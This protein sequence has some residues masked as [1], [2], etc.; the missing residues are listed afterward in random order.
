VRLRHI[1]ILTVV[2]SH[3]SRSRLGGWRASRRHAPRHATAHH[4]TRGA[5]RLGSRRRRA[6]ARPAATGRVDEHRSRFFARL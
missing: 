3:Q 2:K 1:D 6:R 5:D 4:S